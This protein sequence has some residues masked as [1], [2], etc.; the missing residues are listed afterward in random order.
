[1]LANGPA[2]RYR[3]GQQG[4]EGGLSAVL[5]VVMRGV[6]DGGR[7]RCALMVTIPS[8]GAEFYTVPGGAEGTVGSYVEVPAVN[9][10]ITVF[11]DVA[12]RVGCLA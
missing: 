5:A 1:M 12:N 8:V 2:I 11:I 9:V 3:A 10:V 4:P 6:G 7:S